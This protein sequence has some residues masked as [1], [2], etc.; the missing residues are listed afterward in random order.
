MLGKTLLA[1]T[2]LV[3]CAVT[4]HAGEKAKQLRD[5]I[6]ARL[7]KLGEPVH[8]VHGIPVTVMIPG[9]HG[10]PNYNYVPLSERGDVFDNFSRDK[11][12][13][14]VSWYGFVAVRETSCYSYSQNRHI[15]ITEIGTNAIP[16]TGTG[17]PVKR[18]GVPLT[19]LTGP[20]TEFNVGIYSATASGSPGYTELAG[21]ST[22]AGDTDDCCTAVRWVDINLKLDAGK[23]YFV[24]VTC[25]TSQTDCLGSWNMEDTDF[26]G[27]AR[28]YWREMHAATGTTLTCPTGSCSVWRLSTFL[29][30]EPAAIVN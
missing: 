8:V 7:M 9:T 21:A 19:S 17:K 22:T 3:L 24:E 12:A 28:D 20:S 14:F 25:A 16:I 15:C 30:T 5:R 11:N 23:E 1:T 13:E 4:A 29:P 6:T 10:R 27:D 2:A 26:S 18:I